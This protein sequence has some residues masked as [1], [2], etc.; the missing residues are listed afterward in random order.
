[1]KVLYFT[2]PEVNDAYLI[3]SIIESNGDKVTVV[4]SK[5]TLELV[6]TNSIEMIICDR[7]RAL[8]TQDILDHLPKAVINIHPSFLPYN[9]GYYPNFWSHRTQTPSGCT[10]HYVDQGIDTGEIISQ[11]L[12]CFSQNDTLRT[13]YETLR[14]LSVN[15]FSMIYPRIRSKNINSVAQP[16]IA[17]S[18]TYYKKDFDGIHQKLP[19]G[20]DTPISD[21]PFLQL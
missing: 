1:M 11:T 2:N 14:K 19:Q 5:P 17:A 9:R 13:S 10:I 18:K 12:I 21:I 4:T 6:E 16:E 15:L 3:P 7:A 20:W 8:I